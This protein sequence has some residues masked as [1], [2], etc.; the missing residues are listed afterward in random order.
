MI[1]KLPGRRLGGRNECAC[2]SRLTPAPGCSD[3]FRIQSD[4][5]FL[6]Q[7]FLLEFPRLALSFP[8]A[9][10][11]LSLETLLLLLTTLLLERA[12]FTLLAQKERLFLS[13]LLDTQH[14]SERDLIFFAVL[15]EPYAAFGR[16]WLS[17]GLV[18]R[19]G[20]GNLSL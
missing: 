12:T 1:F 14:I 4:F 9:S 13:L 10:F 2:A 18:R 16:G 5:S 17:F 3:F 7:G 6:L 20:R 11:S 15:G 8:L 19:D